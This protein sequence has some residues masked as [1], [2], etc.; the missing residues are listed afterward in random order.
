MRLEFPEFCHDGQKLSFLASQLR[1]TFS[2]DLLKIMRR[3][4]RRNLATRRPS[5]FLFRNPR[6]SRE[7][8][9]S[10]LAELRLDLEFL[11]P[12][13]SGRI[14]VRESDEL[15]LALDS[16]AVYHTA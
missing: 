1:M 15:V 8:T 16:P 9:R 12:E 10:D 4:R 14:L 11:R 6:R 13:A 5:T 2:P 3:L 7:S